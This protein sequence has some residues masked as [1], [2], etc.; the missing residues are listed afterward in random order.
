MF[1]GKIHYFSLTPSSLKLKQSNH[2][3]QAVSS[4][5]NP[6]KTRFWIFS[7]QKKTVLSFFAKSP[8]RRWRLLEFDLI[9]FFPRL[10]R[11]S[12]IPLKTGVHHGDLPNL[13]M[14]NIYW[15]LMVI[16]GDLMVIY[17]DL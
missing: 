15:D 3:I 16:Y 9:D 7:H 14:T 17:G 11:G 6:V 12:E 10:I 1:S 8:F 4:P 5:Q 13:V 2:Q